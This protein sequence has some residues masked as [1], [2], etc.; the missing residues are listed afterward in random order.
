MHSFIYISFYISFRIYVSISSRQFVAVA[1]IQLAS[2]CDAD[3]NDLKFL[4]CQAT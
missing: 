4:T 1:E 3:S 2:V